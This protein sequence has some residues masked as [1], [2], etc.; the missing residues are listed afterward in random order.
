LNDRIA[1]LA[2]QAN[3]SPDQLAARRKAAAAKAG[4]TG[5]PTNQV[6]EGLRGPTSADVKAAQSMS[7]QDRMSMIRNMVAGLAERLKEQPDNIAGWQR[8]ARSYG[9]L[10]EAAKA[11]DAYAHLAKKQPD[12]VNALSDYANSIAKTL[13]KDANI[14]AE[15]ATLGDQILELDSK[16]TGALWLTGLARAQSGDSKGARERWTRLLALLDPKSPQRA[17]VEKNLKTL[18]N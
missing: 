17:D 2:P 12:N 8:L 7:S 10:G 13:E 4:K 6:A 18:E 5:A 14:P 3:V 16:H 11:R 9:V 1:K 15:L